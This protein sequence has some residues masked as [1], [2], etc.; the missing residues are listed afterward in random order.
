MKILTL[1]FLACVIMA[2]QKTGC[3]VIPFTLKAI[4]DTAPAILRGNFIDDYGIRYSINDTVFIQHPSGKYHIIRW[5]N[6]EQYLI[7]RNDAKNSSDGGKYT[8]I[9]Y[10]R[11]ENMQPY[12]W[13]FC[14]TVY[15]AATDSL[16]EVAIA[17]DWTNP[18][19]G[20]GGYP[21][22]RMKRN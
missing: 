15:N 17:A 20:C 19:K 12:G 3:P 18:K 5:N 21:F 7:A 8:R 11:F 6:K 9:D 4:P 10:M 14:L 1:S 13:G 16:A 22:S 2:H